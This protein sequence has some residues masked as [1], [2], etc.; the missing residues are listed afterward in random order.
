MRTS[1]SDVRLWVL[2]TATTLPLPNAIAEAYPSA[3]SAPTTATSA[4]IV[5]GTARAQA[6]IAH[7][8]TDSNNDNNALIG[9]K[10]ELVKLELSV[11]MRN[12]RFTFGS[13]Y[14]RGLQASRL[15][16]AAIEI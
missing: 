14:F 16:E 13:G 1:C 15:C 9:K 4:V 12:G 2:C 8:A 6:L 3:D 11:N 5:A 10:Q 7:T